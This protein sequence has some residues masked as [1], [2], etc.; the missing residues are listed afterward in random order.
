MQNPVSTTEDTGSTNSGSTPGAEFALAG[1]SKTSAKQSSAPDLTAASDTGES[2]T[3]NL[4]SIKT[5]TL[6]GTAE[7]GTTVT[8]YDDHHKIVV[9]TAVT[10][11]T[12][13][14]S[15]TTIALADGE[16]KLTAKVK[17]TTENG[18]DPDGSNGNGV[19][20]PKTITIIIDTAAPVAPGPADLTAATDSGRSNID[21]ITYFTKPTFTGTAPAGVTVTLYDGDIKLGSGV[22]NRAGIWTIT[23]TR[24]MAQGVHNVVATTVDAAGN[25]ARAPGLLVTIDTEVPPPG[26]PDLPAPSDSG[27]SDTD[28]ITK[29]AT[30]KLSGTAEAIAIVNVYDGDRLLGTT[31]ADVEGNWSIDSPALLDGIH[32]ITATA[33]DVAGNVS[34]RSPA[35]AVTVDTVAP[36]APVELDLVA[37]SD[38]GASDRDDITNVATPVIK[39][40]AEANAIVNLYDG[41]V[42]VGT[43]LADAA[44]AWTITTSVLADGIHNLT[45]TATDVAGNVSPPSSLLPVMVDTVAPAA[46]VTL[47]LAT[48]S[49][50]GRTSADDITNF[51]T[52]L[53]TGTAE[54]GS[55]VSLFDGDTR[56]G[57]ALANDVGIWSVTTSTLLDGVHHLTAT[58]TDAAGNISPRSAPLAVTIDTVPPAAP[59]SLDMAAASDS[60]TS[61]NDDLTRVTTPVITGSAEAGSIVILYE[62]ATQ[63][64]TA[65][66]SSAGIWSITTAPLADGIHA[67][68]ATAT[69]VAGNESAPS[70][71]LS[72]T[73]DTTAPLPHHAPSLDPASDDGVSNT[74]NVT[75]NTTPTVVCHT[76]PGAIVTLYDGST[77]VGTAF[78]DAHGKWSITTTALTYGSHSLQ[79]T[80]TDAAG[81]VSSPSAALTITV[82]PKPAAPSAPVFAP[83]SDNGASTTDGLTSDATPTVTGTAP[84]GTTVTI[85]DGTTACGTGTVNDDG[86][87]SITCTPLGQ[88]SHNLIARAT[89]AGGYTSDPS[90]PLNCTID[91]APPVAPVCGGAVSGSDT[92]VSSTDNV[93]SNTTPTWAGSAEPGSTVSVYEGDT[94]LGSGTAGPNGTW[95]VTSSPLNDGVHVLTVIA[96]DPAGNVS[97]AGTI[98]PLTVDTSIAAPSAPSLA[99]E[100]DSGTSDTDNVTSIATPTITGSAEPGSTVTLYSGSTVLGSAVAGGAGGGGGSGGGGGG[101]GGGGS[102]SISV[103]SPLVVGTHFLTVVTT[104]LAGNFTSSPVGEI[105]I[106]L[107][108]VAPSAPDLAAVS[109]SGASNVDNIT[110]VT[111]PVFNGTAI[112]GASV[113]L[114]EG[115]TVRGTGNADAAGA[116]SITANGPLSQG[117]HSLTALVTNNVGTS[118]SSPALSVTIDSTAPAAP[119]APDLAAA[120]DNG[121]SSTDNATTVTTPVI[122]GSAEPGA[123]VTLYEGSTVLG[124]SVAN[125]AG[126]WSV[127]STA[128]NLGTH[129]LTATAKDQAGNTSPVSSGLSIVIA[130]MPSAPGAPDLAAASDSGVSSNDNITNVNLPVFTGTAETGTTVTLLEGATVRGAGV[131]D[132]SGTWTITANTALA[133][134]S[135]VFTASATNPIGTSAV[136]GNLAIVMDT[137]APAAPVAPDLIS[138]SG[139]S[140]VDNLTNVSR[141]SLSGTSEANAIINLY[142]GA[143]LLG[144]A[145]AD[146]LGAWTITTTL[147]LGNGVH[148]LTVNAT[149]RA[150]NTSATSPSLPVTIDTVVPVPSTPDM[151]AASD[152]GT[153]TTDN[154]TTITTPTFTGTAEANAV[155]QLREGSTVL[156]STTANGSG[157]W[158]I[159]S[160][161]LALGTHHL[162]ALAID[163][164]NN[165]S[166]ASDAL[167]VTISVLPAAPGAPDLSD[168]S[169]T[170]ASSTD[171]RTNDTTPTFEGTVEPGAIVTLYKG[172]TVLGTTTANT[173]GAWSVT[174][175]P[176]SQATHVLTIKVTNGIGTSVASPSL[177]V[178]IDTTVNAPTVAPNLD[179]ASDT[180]TS[181]IDN[182]TSDTTPSFSGNTSMEAGTVKLYEGAVLL[183]S[184]T[185]TNGAWSATSS[186]L[187]NGVHNI[188]AVLVDLAG[189]VSAPSPS[190]AVTIDNAAPI[191][192]SGPDLSAGTDL[193]SSNTDNL[194]SAKTVVL[195]GVTDGGVKVALYSTANMSTPVA[196]TTA[197]AAGAWAVAVSGMPEGLVN[198]VAVTTDSAG[199]VSAPSAPLAITFDYTA[200][201]APSAPDLA[202][203]ADTGRFDND[204]YTMAQ[205]VRFVGTAAPGSAITLY[206]KP[207]N[208][209]TYV[210][211]YGVADADGNWSITAPWSSYTNELLQRW[212]YTVT[213]KDLA[214]NLSAA[215]APLVTFW[216]RAGPSA[217]AVKMETAS[218]SAIVGD[219]NT[220][221]ATPTFTGLTGSA[222]GSVELNATLTV[223]DNGVE[224]ASV[225]VTQGPT[226]SIT[227]PLSEGYHPIT[228]KQADLSGNLSLSSA[229][230]VVID[231]AEA[232]P[233]VPDL[234]SGNDDGASNSDNVTSVNKPT[235]IG[236]TSPGA[237]VFLYDGATQIGQ[238]VAN[239]SG[240]WGAPITTA[241]APG[242]HQITAKAIDIAGNV[243]PLTAALTVTITTTALLSAP[244][245]AVG[246][247]PSPDS[248][249]LVELIGSPLP[250]DGQGWMFG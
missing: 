40:K 53:I 237:K 28:N 185:T 75:G 47:D 134:G 116:W 27:R 54:P 199:N 7:A 246:G 122:T 15:I 234:H 173:S 118:V 190:L 146:G 220:S 191:N 155:I 62:G 39:G 125:G 213:E 104:D 204:N 4:T 241:L 83:G 57:T 64:G 218:D 38:S 205:H 179:T 207:P 103:N 172:T 17:N 202:P 215:S 210:R 160:S 33:T 117:V 229:I 214:G 138:D 32:I 51:N 21:D 239:S 14:W 101:S 88:G 130:Q 133:Q 99:P 8:L 45:A 98:P 58:A 197:D 141:P 100:S 153:Y 22:A 169:D 92:G 119:S 77:V 127:T 245:S 93:T 196:N 113:T 109:D 211:G 233:S 106:G 69:D 152:T 19:Q 231:T 78:A 131:A 63:V 121:S 206:G 188:T 195:S 136:S 29:I 86:Q 166:L 46:P 167:P 164:A 37:P 184:T 44:G 228:F 183:G 148:G 55:T 76:E 244:E 137:T 71:P 182:L 226:W 163:A 42:L 157:A 26:L 200:S 90:A 10:D 6:V 171:N 219:N 66:T 142:E 230:G 144:S 180:G 35:L 52:P 108:P 156:G 23:A 59:A 67:L 222:T 41:E 250:V 9:G 79:S 18:P 143:T 48:P 135:H 91:S 36:P 186:V 187:A 181:S 242:A 13:H 65:L 189:N 201:A 82:D 120:S 132:G 198:V 238:S 70:S 248:Q 95:S 84:A 208:N 31:L 170:G 151:A 96:T 159:T 235:F 25:V 223:F 97:P 175:S 61:N 110:S 154:V 74:D 216:D 227:V 236:T 111:T 102:W 124:A 145:T 150:G 128:L 56:I 2:N 68:T 72:V 20:G 224:I 243:S 16:H 73:I 178:V 85:Y 174:S 12:G 203:D 1:Q 123:T 177:N 81:N 193:G 11:A 161:T 176:L 5:P 158:S 225:F 240:Y 212:E 114:Y 165:V 60:G 140:S 115:A 107:A 147:Q 94:L 247:L 209:V 194:T 105:T 232:A 129:T 126:A 168:A 50:S 87:W 43:A 112:A 24:T 162:T 217:P 249:P 80:S 49:D 221:D 149:D 192:Y 3:D 89:N 34:L 139:S 30:P